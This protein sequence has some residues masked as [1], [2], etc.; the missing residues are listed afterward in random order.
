MTI[1]HQQQPDDMSC[2]HTCLAM[3]LGIPVS[4]VVKRI[5]TFD[6]GMNT[7]DLYGALDICKFEWNALIFNNLVVNGF[8]MATVPS[9]NVQSGGH[10]VILELTDEKITVHD[11][12]KGREGKKFY[13]EGGCPLKYFSEL[14]LI[15]KVGFL[16]NKEIQLS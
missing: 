4:E 11:P 10:A 16:P 8:Y 15:G 9:V 2:S 1:I 13:G 6:G 12:N 3:L 14:V 7:K 5:K